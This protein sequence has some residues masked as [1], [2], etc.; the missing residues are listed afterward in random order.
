MRTEPG[1]FLPLRK[2][3]A[4]EQLYRMTLNPSNYFLNQITWNLAFLMM[5]HKWL[6]QGIS[7]GNYLT[8]GL[9]W[10]SSALRLGQVHRGHTAC[11]TPHCV[12]T[13]RARHTAEIKEHWALQVV[14]LKTFPC[15][16][17]VGIKKGTDPVSKSRGRDLSPSISQPTFAKLT[18]LMNSQAKRHSIKRT[19]LGAGEM[20]R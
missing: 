1:V 16:Q 13:K 19:D 17:W 3:D 5:C 6:M 7:H 2:N 20:A 11:F 8:G 10:C 4:E 12:I 15:W 14:I 9:L 18:W